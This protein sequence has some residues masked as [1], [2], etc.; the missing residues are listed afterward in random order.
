MPKAKQY[1]VYIQ[2]R[3]CKKDF[4][5][6]YVFISRNLIQMT[7]FFVLSFLGL[8]ISRFL[9]LIKNMV[10]SYTFEINLK[11][12]PKNWQNMEKNPYTYTYLAFNPF[13]QTFTKFETSKISGCADDP[14]QKFKRVTMWNVLTKQH[15]SRE[16]IGYYK[17]SGISIYL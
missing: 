2:K 13:I 14:A 4:M 5:E 15:R 6:L 9:Q 16:E 1:I 3:R 10:K 17:H 12:G 11:N 7:I 8:I